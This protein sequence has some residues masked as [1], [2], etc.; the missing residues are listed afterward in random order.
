M[1]KKQKARPPDLDEQMRQAA[2]LFA[3]LGGRARMKQLTP[4]ER[5][6][7]GRRGGIASAASK[8]TKKT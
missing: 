7:L 8:R 3:K 2:R 6:E 5:A 4:K 1:A